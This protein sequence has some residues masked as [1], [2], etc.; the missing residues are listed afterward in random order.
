[1][2]ELHEVERLRS[3]V[4]LDLDLTGAESLFQDGVKKPRRGRFRPS[5]MRPLLATAVL[6]AAG[7]TA[8]AYFSATP[9]DEKTVPVADVSVVMDR[10]AARA[11]ADPLPTPRSGQYIYREVQETQQAD[12]YEQDGSARWLEHQRTETWQSVNGA[13]PDLTRSKD[14]QRL[15]MPGRTLPPEAT[16]MPASAADEMVTKPCGVRPPLERPFLDAVP[17]DADALLRLIDKVD[18]PVD[19]D[20]D[21]AEDDRG[22]RLWETAS[23]LLVGSAAPAPVQAALYKAIAKIPGVALVGDSVDAA[24]RHGFAVARVNGDERNELIFDR[25]TYRFLGER[26]VVVKSGDSGPAGAFLGASAILRTAVVDAPPKPGPHAQ[27]GDC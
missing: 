20:G 15:P 17:A 23:D 1:M 12:A 22:A 13:H 11:L 18:D 2:T 7:A 10:A 4:P 19:D 25:A 6:A 8:G 27:Y 3:E 9:G 14:R 21:G 16:R 5:P 26:S 24:G